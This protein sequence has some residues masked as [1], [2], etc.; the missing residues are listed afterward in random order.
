MPISSPHVPEAYAFL[1]IY[2]LDNHNYQYKNYSNKHVIFSFKMYF[3][4]NHRSFLYFPDG[5][6]DQIPGYKNL[7]PIL[8]SLPT[9][10]LTIFTSAPTNSQRLAISFM[11]LTRVANIAFDA[12][13]VISADGI[14]INITLK[15][16]S[17]IER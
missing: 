1:V 16:L 2:S 6:L 11:K 8:V 15:L 12:Y 3:T 17:I 13:L 9:H 4:N 5:M 7:V 10:L 14:S